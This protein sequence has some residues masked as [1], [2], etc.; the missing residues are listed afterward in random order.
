MKFY[1]DI[2]IS[3][4]LVMVAFMITLAIVDVFFVRLSRKI[5]CRKL[6]NKQKEIYRYFIFENHSCRETKEEFDLDDSFTSYVE[7]EDKGVNKNSYFC[8]DCGYYTGCKQ[9]AK[10]GDNL[11]KRKIFKSYFEQ[12]YK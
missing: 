10:D 11:F 12:L 2:F 7:S 1:L 9:T 6:T 3:A 5:M 8:S 4:V